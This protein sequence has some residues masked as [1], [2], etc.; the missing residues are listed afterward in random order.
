MFFKFFQ[1]V[2]NLTEALE[3]ERE[4]LLSKLERLLAEAKSEQIEQLQSDEKI[5]KLQ[6]F[7]Q[8]LLVSEKIFYVLNLVL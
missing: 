4:N 7:V 1:F 8:V 5:Q 3:T 6:H 2:L